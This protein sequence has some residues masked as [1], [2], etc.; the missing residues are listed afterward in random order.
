MENAVSFLV[1]DTDIHNSTGVLLETKRGELIL[2]GQLAAC[3]MN[4]T[5]GWMCGHRLGPLHAPSQLVWVLLLL[6]A[7][8]HAPYAPFTAVLPRQQ[9]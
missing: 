9:E 6:L 8:A 2:R 1:A 3:T 4:R 5:A 7:K